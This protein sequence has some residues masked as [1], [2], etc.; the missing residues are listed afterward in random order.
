MIKRQITN[1]RVSI[2]RINDELEQR[3]KTQKRI[4]K[5]DIFRVK[6]QNTILKY[7]EAK[8]NQLILNKVLKLVFV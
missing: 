6:R 1:S 2:P 5:W 4:S 3:E 7:I 8:R